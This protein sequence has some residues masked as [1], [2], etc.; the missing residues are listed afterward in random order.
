MDRGVGWIRRRGGWVGSW[1]EEGEVMQNSLME[2]ALSYPKGRGQAGMLLSQNFRE[3]QQPLRIVIPILS[4]AK[5]RVRP[6]Q[7]PSIRI[8]SVNV[9]LS[10]VEA[11]HRKIGL[12]NL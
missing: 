7:L 11:E 8:K 2:R 12:P 4:G 5:C 9:N 10:G 1:G 6:R 3:G